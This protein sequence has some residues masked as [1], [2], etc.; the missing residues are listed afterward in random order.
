MAKL[1]IKLTDGTIMENDPH[2][3]VEAVLDYIK[4]VLR[5]S[6]ETSKISNINIQLID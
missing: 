2:P 4:Q 1:Q 5:V 6:P 3:D